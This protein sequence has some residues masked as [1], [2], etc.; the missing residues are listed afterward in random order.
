MSTDDFTGRDFWSAMRQ[1]VANAGIEPISLGE[2]EDERWQ[3]ILA[4]SIAVGNPLSLGMTQGDLMRAAYALGQG[5]VLAPFL[6]P[7]GYLWEYVLEGTDPVYEGTERVVEL[8]RI[9][10]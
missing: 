4:A 3:K 5:G 1:F 7:T 9:A 2:P 10:A 8:I 6:P